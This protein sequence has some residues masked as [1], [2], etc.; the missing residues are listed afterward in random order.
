MKNPKMNRSIETS[1]ILLIRRVR[2]KVLTYRF[3]FKTLKVEYKDMSP[4]SGQKKQQKSDKRS[5]LMSNMRSLKF[6]LHENHLRTVKSKKE[7]RQIVATQLV[8]KVVVV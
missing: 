6:V 7:I 5:K 1:K 8:E 4:L 2:T 3:H